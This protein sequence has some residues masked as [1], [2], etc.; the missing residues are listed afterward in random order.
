MLEGGPHEPDP[1]NS[2][3]LCFSLHRVPLTYVFCQCRRWKAPRGGS[4]GHLEGNRLSGLRPL[5][6]AATCGALLSLHRP[7]LTSTLTHSLQSDQTLLNLPQSAC[8]VQALD[9]SLPPGG[10]EGRSTRARVE[11]PARR[12]QS[13]IQSA[14]LTVTL[15]IVIVSRSASGWRNPPHG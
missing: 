5:R 15:L 14:L 10:A 12:R 11:S 1:E 7:S 6:P 13:G 4:A 8:S 2:R 3:T 9:D